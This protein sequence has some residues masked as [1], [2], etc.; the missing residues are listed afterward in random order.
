MFAIMPK[1]I[2]IE[3]P[4]PLGEID[5]GFIA[6]FGALSEPIRMQI[7]RMMVD[8]GDEDF[9]CTTLDEELPIAKST[10]SYHV[11]ILRRAGLIS[12][13]K[14]GRNYFYRL[15]DETLES[16]APALLTHLREG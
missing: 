13:R 1:S 3:P 14:A 5:E 16:F 8:Y 2:A 4:Q 11:Q 7:I 9:P 12:V 10:I 15:R 6:V